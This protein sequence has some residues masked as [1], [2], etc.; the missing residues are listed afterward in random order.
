MTSESYLEG[1]QES[2]GLGLNVKHHCVPSG[3]PENAESFAYALGYAADDRPALCAW[4]DRAGRLAVTQFYR[5][6]LADRWAAR[7][8]AGEKS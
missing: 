3:P 6:L 8:I 7:V 2:V 1:L 5:G 4:G